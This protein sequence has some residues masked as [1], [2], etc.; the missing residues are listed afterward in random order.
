MFNSRVPT[1]VRRSTGRA[2]LIVILGIAGLR[3][4]AADDKKP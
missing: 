4:A 2:I 3:T 1:H